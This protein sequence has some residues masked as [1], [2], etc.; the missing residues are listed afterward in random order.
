M[1]H[2]FSAIPNSIML[3]LVAIICLAQFSRAIAVNHTGHAPTREAATALL[4]ANGINTTILDPEL[5]AERLRTLNNLYLVKDSDVKVAKRQSN[6]NAC[7]MGVS[8]FDFAI[9]D[10]N[11]DEYDPITS[12]FSSVGSQSDYLVSAVNGAGPEC[13]SASSITLSGN[14]GFFDI[15]TRQA[16]VGTQPNTQNWIYVSWCEGGGYEWG[17]IPT[18][19]YVNWYWDELFAY[20]YPSNWEPYCDD[21]GDALETYQFSTVAWCNYF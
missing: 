16:Y 6:C 3:S 20:C 4:Q 7:D 17:S 18:A 5:R 1:K 19:F 14:G 21:N 10:L 8:G 15:C 12:G 2:T 11:Y 13:L 9:V